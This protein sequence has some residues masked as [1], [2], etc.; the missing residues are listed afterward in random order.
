MRRM[1]LLVSVLALIGMVALPA[2]ADHVTK[3][4]YTIAECADPGNPQNAA[5]MKVWYPSEHRIHI[6]G[7]ENLYH[8]YLLDGDAWLPIG[9]NTTMANV[10]ASFPSFEG[11]FWGTFDIESTLGDFEGRWS[12]GAGEFGRASGSSDDGTLLKVTL[13]LADDGLPALPVADACG[14][15]EYEVFSG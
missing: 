5:E 14:V 8:V 1:I 2:G 11:A 6:R 9:T 13:G 15:A 12:W 10:N 4:T 7:A 3:T